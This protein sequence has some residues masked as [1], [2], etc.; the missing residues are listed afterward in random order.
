MSNVGQREF[1]AQQRVVEFFRDS[2]RY[3]YLW[4]AGRTEISTATSKKATSPAG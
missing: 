4:P 1:H 3:A 2:L